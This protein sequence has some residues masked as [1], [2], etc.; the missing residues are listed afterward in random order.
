[1]RHVGRTTEN[2]RLE[3]AGQSKMQ[4]WKMR[5]WKMRN[6]TVMVENAGL[7]N[8]EPIRMV[9]KCKIRKWGKRHCMDYG[10]TCI[11]YVWSILQDATIECV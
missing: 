4:G 9:G 6:Q 2:A 8:A 10:T 3:D 11:P 7:E 1:M 5:D